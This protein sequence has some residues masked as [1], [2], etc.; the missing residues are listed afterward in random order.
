MGRFEYCELE[1]NIRY[2]HDKR[3]A[4]YKRKS[5]IEIYSMQV[6]LKERERQ[7]TEKVRDR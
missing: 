1:E 4:D 5:E 6:Y 2:R 3:L 7:R